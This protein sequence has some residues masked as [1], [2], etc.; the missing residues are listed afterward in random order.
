MAALGVALAALSLVG[1]HH[2]P[3]HHQRHLPPAGEP[4]FQ[5]GAVESYPGNEPVPESWGLPLRTAVES[6]PEHDGDHR[7]P[8]RDAVEANYKPWVFDAAV[9]VFDVGYFF[10]KI[11]MWFAN[12]RKFHN[13][14]WYIF[15]YFHL[16]EFPGNYVDFWGFLLFLI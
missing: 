8:L 3:G 12:N 9:V 5:R 10:V 6:I 1:S 11:N 7:Q 4:S 16:V 2:I 13:I 15:L 14:V